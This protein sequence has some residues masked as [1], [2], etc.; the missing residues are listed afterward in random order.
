[1]KKLFQKI[2]A[3]SERGFQGAGGTSNVQGNAKCK[4]QNSKLRNSLFLNF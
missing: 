2:L 1:M 3:A 4:E